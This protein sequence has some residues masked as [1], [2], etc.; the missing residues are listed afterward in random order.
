M[1]LP[2]TPPTDY[3]P[4]WLGQFITQL[5]QALQFCVKTNEQTG[6]VILRSPDGQSWALTVSN[7]GVL[8]TTVMDGSER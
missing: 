4:E 2:N 1:T 7:S 3:S 6:R 5:Q 8:T